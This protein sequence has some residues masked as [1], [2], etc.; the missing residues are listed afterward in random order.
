MLKGSGLA[1]ALPYL[2]A[3]S[4]DKITKQ[5]PKRFCCTY[6][7]YGAYLCS[8]N[9]EHK[10]WSF[11]PHEN[12]KKYSF[13]DVNRV[14]EKHRKDISFLA[15]LSH[16]QCRKMGGHDTAD[17]FLTGTY[18]KAPFSKNTESLDQLIA[19]SI[20]GQTR[21][22]SM[23]LSAD[24][25]IGEFTRAHTLSFTHTGNPVPTMNQPRQIFERMFTLD[26]GRKTS[27]KKKLSNTGSALDMLMDHTKSM[28]LNMSRA[29]Q[30]KMD[31]YLY[32]VRSIE[33]RVQRSKQWLDVPL[34]VINAKHINFDVNDETPKEFI[35]CMYDLIHLAYQTDQ[36]RVATYQIGS[37]NGAT[38]I[39]GKY[40]SILG[41]GSMHNVAH[42]AN[43]PG[44]A[45]K[46]GAWNRFL[47]E[48]YATFLDKLSNTREGNGSLLDNTVLLFGTS[49]S[50]THVNTNYPL[51]L[52][53]GKNMGFQHGQSLKYDQ[54]IPMN[55]LLLS[56]ANKVTKPMISFGDSTGEL[57]ELS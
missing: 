29:D 57:T 4:E 22:A 23:T 54:H 34:P 44:G 35:T 42:G 9:S 31:E 2:E 10:K 1:L 20:G 38:S 49:N 12:G 43:K 53:G 40:P 56:I 48:Q 30:H 5:L 33:Q 8:P 27:V 36:C 46:Q 37:M 17:T 39:A 11:L 14:L 7:P 21:Y 45:E 55:N 50:K 18:L 32:S 47:L 15:G 13:T 26:S 51:I 25:G 52:A 28:M 6:F 24:G 19:K 41:L 3:M 16:P